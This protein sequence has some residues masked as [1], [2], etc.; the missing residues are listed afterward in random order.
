MSTNLTA[1]QGGLRVIKPHWEQHYVPYNPQAKYLVVV[2]EPKEVFV[3]G[4]YFAQSMSGSILDFAYS[5]TNGS[6][7]F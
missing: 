4:Y 2:R 5:A 7:S 6:L 1:G 3:S